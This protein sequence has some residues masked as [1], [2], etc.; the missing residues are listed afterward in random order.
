MAD[1]VLFLR[2]QSILMFQDN[3]VLVVI[4]RG[5][6]DDTGLSMPVHGKGIE[7]VAGADFLNKGAVCDHFV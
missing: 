2:L 4:H 1:T 3:S 6:S 5:T 7:I